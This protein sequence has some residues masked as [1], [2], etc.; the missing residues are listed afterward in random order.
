M[1]KQF[2]YLHLLHL[3]SG[4]AI[5]LV[6]AVVYVCVFQVCICVCVCVTSYYTVRVVNLGI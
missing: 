2:L 5:Q 6:V 3:I 4:K 1:T